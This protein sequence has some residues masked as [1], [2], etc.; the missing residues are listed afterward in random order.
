MY[1]TGD[2]VSL[3]PDGSVEFCGR[4][5]DQLKIHG[6]RIELGEI[7]TALRRQRGV[8]DAVLVAR[9]DEAGGKELIAYVVPARAVDAQRSLSEPGGREVPTIQ[10]L[11]DGLREQLPGPMIP[12]AFVWIDKLPL[13]RNGKIDRNALPAVV[14]EGNTGTAEA[15]RE[16]TQSE[17]AVCD[18]FSALLKVQRMGVDD[19]F[20]DMGGHSLLA[21]SAVS[22]IRDEFGVDVGLR[23][24][25][26]SPTPAGIA[27]IVDGMKRAPRT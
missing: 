5:D 14:R 23:N 15:M 21:I 24:L 18:I 13:T 11:R 10:R 19:D 9:E 27:A 25:F 3:L 12:S 26:S 4:L 7:E 16:R 17:K 8:G 22:R 6:F 2:V 1:R 20:F